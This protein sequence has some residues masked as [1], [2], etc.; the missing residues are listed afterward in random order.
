MISHQVGRLTI[1]ERA[2]GKPAAFAT[3]LEVVDDHVP[4]Q[5]HKRM[6]HLTDATARL[7]F[8]A[9]YETTQ[10]D[11]GNLQRGAY[12]APTLSIP[13]EVIMIER[14]ASVLAGVLWRAIQVWRSVRRKAGELRGR[15]GPGLEMMKVRKGWKPQQ[16]DV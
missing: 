6:I 14:T 10:A 7:T 11:S 5:Q 16:R 1:G 2:G 12:V 3:E 13:S 9:S 15:R 4:P 8:Y